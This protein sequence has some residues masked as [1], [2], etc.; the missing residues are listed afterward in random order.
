[1]LPFCFPGKLFFGMVEFVGI[2][3]SE[4]T[5]FVCSYN[6]KSLLCAQCILLLK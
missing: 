3:F 6:K 5:I 4:E 2:K 1:M